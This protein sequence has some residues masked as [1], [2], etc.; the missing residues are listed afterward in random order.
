MT[1]RMDRPGFDNPLR[2]RFAPSSTGPLD[3][4]AAR[5]A[6]FNWLLARATGGSFVVCVDDTGESARAQRACAAARSALARPG[7]GR[8]LRRRRR[9]GAVPP[10]GT[11]RA[12]RSARRSGCSTAGA[13]TSAT[14]RCGFACRPARRWCTTSSKATSRSI[15]TRSR[16]S[17]CA[18]RIGTMTYDL[19][20]AVDD[21]TMRIDL[22]LRGDEHL[23]DTPRQMMIARALGIR[24]AA[25]RARRAS[26]SAPTGTSSRARTDR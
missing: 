8:G 5:T 13:H 12:P 21:A 11:R 7:L 1:G 22:V 24:A 16:T 15:T 4:G 9:N 25:L 26:S 3:V 6:L 14:A 19:V 23:D 2:V 20:A 17:S 18:N 10:F